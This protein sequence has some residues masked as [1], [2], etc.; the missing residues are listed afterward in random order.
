VV[1]DRRPI[2]F[3]RELP[4]GRRELWVAAADGSVQ[5]LLDSPPPW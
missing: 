2:A 5:H 1:P 4:D 3:A